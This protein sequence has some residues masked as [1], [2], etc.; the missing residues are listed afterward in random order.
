M[1]DGFEAAIGGVLAAVTEAALDLRSNAE[2]MTST[3]TRTADS[4]G[5]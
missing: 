3:A 2:A 5:A 4:L 1:A